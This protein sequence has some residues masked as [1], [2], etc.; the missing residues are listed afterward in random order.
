MSKGERITVYKAQ[1]T[2]SKPPISI[3]T[4]LNVSKRLQGQ[5][6]IPKPTEKALPNTDQAKPMA[7]DLKESMI[8]FGTGIKWC[9]PICS[10]STKPKDRVRGLRVPALGFWHEH[11]CR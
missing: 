2:C 10:T 11:S 1:G 7:S 9:R 5:G 6:L 3:S 8:N 4:Q